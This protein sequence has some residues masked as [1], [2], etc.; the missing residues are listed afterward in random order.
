MGLNS[1]RAHIMCALLLGCCFTARCA[2]FDNAKPNK[3]MVS[4]ETES[5]LL[6]V[7]PDSL[8]DKDKYDIGQMRGVKPLTSHLRPHRPGRAQYPPSQE[9]VWE[10]APVHASLVER[11]AMVP[12]PHSPCNTPILPAQKASGDWRFVQD[13]RPVNDAVHASARCAKPRY[14][15]ICSASTG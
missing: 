12:C 15:T 9:A 2:W 10:I 5:P 11:G 14:S 7:L 4:M 3:Q 13:L 1:P 6:A 8:W